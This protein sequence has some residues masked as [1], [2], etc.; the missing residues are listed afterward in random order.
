MLARE[1]EI[2]SSRIALF[3]CAWCHM[4]GHAQQSAAERSRLHQAG[5]FYREWTQFA[6]KAFISD[7]F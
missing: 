3:R 7:S 1:S 4:A 6:G 2:S 5:G